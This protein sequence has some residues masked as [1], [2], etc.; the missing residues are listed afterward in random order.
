[1]DLTTTQTIQTVGFPIFA[2]VA[3]AGFMAFIIRWLLKREQQQYSD[4]REDMKNIIDRFEKQGISF[5][6]QLNVV[7]ETF[8][9]E[10]RKREDRMDKQDALMEQWFTLLKTKDELIINLITSKHEALVG[11]LQKYFNTRKAEEEGEQNK[12]T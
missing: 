2:T 7:S 8:Q 10:S 3:I 1:M 4:H 11:Q 5:V 6:S 12:V 9:A